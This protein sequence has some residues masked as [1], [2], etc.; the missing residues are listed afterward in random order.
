MEYCSLGDLSHY[1][2]QVRTN[3]SMKR[4]SAGG[5]PERVVRHFLKQLGNSLSLFKK[6]TY[7]C[8]S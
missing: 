5:L 7:V 4:S 1:I 2:K 6:Y 3:K 8:R